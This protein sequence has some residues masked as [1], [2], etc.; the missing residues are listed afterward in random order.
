MIHS[1]PNFISTFLCGI[2]VV[3]L[4]LHLDWALLPF[5][6]SAIVDS[7]SKTFPIHGVEDEEAP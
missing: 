2:S 5:D 1:L 6:Q 3:L 7:P 4:E